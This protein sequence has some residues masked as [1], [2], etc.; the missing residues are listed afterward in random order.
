VESGDDIV[1]AARLLARAERVACSTGAGISRESGIP[2]FREA[3]EGLWAR[4]DP[5]ELATRE[6]FRRNPALV[7]KWYMSRRKF[8]RRARPNPGHLA[9]VELERRAPSFTLITQN[10]DNLHR[11]AGNREVVELH[12]N[13]ERFKCFD[14]DH[15]AEGVPD[16]GEEPPRCKSCGSYLRPDVVWFGEF[17]SESV[18]A[19]A[20]EA[21][22]RCDVMLVVGTSGI[23]HPAASLPFEAREA[24]ASVIEVNPEPSFITPITD[25]SL[26]GPS[27]S[28]LPSVLEA[29]RRIEPPEGPPRDRR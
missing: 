11:R 22:R 10:I 14:R 15:P 21:S 28:V 16:D 29:M 8:I 25:L 19:R 9:L 3:G 13:I 26:R 27:G 12:G 5:E 7:W 23:V 6:G 1:L 4:Y 2:T 24:G 17:L 20:W 18:T